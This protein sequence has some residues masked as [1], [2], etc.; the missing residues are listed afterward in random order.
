M[1]NQE[2]SQTG[3]LRV[4][5]L[6]IRL[7]FPGSRPESPDRISFWWGVTSSSLALARFI[8]SSN[9][10]SNRDVLELGS[11]VGLGGL[12]AALK[13]AR[14]TFTDYMDEALDT[15]RQNTIINK[16]YDENVRF[17]NLD[18]EFPFPVGVFDIIIGSEI[19][20]DYLTHSSLEKLMINA[21]KPH[22]VIVIADRDRMVVNRFMGRLIQKGFSCN[23]TGVMISDPGFPLQE[24]TIYVLER[25]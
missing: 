3:V 1:V 8:E 16:A 10:F 25:L 24:I 18:W 22:G 2:S 4:G 11:G 14:V 17:V 7:I 20:Y 23:K 13:G 6:Q 19:V 21:L 5:D 15:A 12:V 9:S